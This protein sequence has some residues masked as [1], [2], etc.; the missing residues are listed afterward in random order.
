[1]NR[2]GAASV[3]LGGGAHGVTG[4]LG[5]VEMRARARA[6]GAAVGLLALVLAGCGGGDGDGDAAPA[7]EETTEDASPTEDE[8]TE[9]AEDSDDAEDTEDS[10]ESGDM[11]QAT[12]MV[13][14]TDLGDILVDAEGMTLYMF[15]PD[16]QGEST[17]YD[18]CATA[19]P[20]L[21]VDAA[22]TAGEG[23]DDSKLGTVERTDGTLQVTYNSWPLYYWAQ[24]AAPGDTTGQAVNNVWWVLDADGEPIRD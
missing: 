10:D 13:A 11:A 18:D 2:G 19:W 14:S 23:A 3:S 7:A 6:A 17:C 15:D 16:A 9:D 5:E 22:P 1:M 21:T 4:I 24:D 12:V 20:P 8:M